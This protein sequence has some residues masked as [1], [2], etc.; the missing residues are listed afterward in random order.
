MSEWTKKEKQINK[1]TYIQNKYIH[2]KS[3]SLHKNKPLFMW[4]FNVT[5]V[6]ED[7]NDNPLPVKKT[8]SLT[9]LLLTQK[10]PS[11]FKKNDKL[12]NTKIQRLNSLITWK[13]L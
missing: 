13:K 8:Q 2:T 5:L 3:V 12:Q 7:A 10:L 4:W 1:C 6:T 9:I 11:V